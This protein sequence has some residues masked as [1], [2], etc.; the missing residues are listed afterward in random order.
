MIYL[1][2]QL[3]HKIDIPNQ[4]HTMNIRAV[5]DAV[6]FDLPKGL[7]EVTNL[8]DTKEGVNIYEEDVRG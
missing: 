6:M 8:T 3:K 4:K 5:K 7:D 1:I 2:L